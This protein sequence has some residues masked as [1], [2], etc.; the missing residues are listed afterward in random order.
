MQ[1]EFIG[2]GPL[3]AL[4]HLVNFFLPAALLAAVSAAGA[5]MLWRKALRGV[6]WARLAG[7]AAAACAVV[8]LVGLVWTGRDGRMATYGAMVLAC[9]L[10]LWWQ[11][12]GPG[13]R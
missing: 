1:P 12:F 2:M 3:D 5:K 11:G 4:L 10:T 13:R 6:P 8:A 7:P 9:A